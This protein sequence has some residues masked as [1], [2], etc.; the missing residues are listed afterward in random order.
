MGVLRMNAQPEKLLYSVNEL[1]AALS[2]CR[3]TVYELFKRGEFDKVKIGSHTYVKVDQVRAF[4]ERSVVSR[5]K[6]APDDNSAT[7]EG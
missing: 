7:R 3:D 5:S 1:C 6:F 2:I 4:I